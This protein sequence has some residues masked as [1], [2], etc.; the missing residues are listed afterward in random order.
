MTKY[1]LKQL[2]K[3]CIFNINLSII[4]NEVIDEGLINVRHKADHITNTLKSK[5]S[6]LNPSSIDIDTINDFLIPFNIKLIKT[7]PHG[8]LAA[9]DKKTSQIFINHLLFF[10]KKSLNFAGISKIKWNILSD[11]IEHEL[12]H[13]E[14]YSRSKGK[15]MKPPKQDMSRDQHKISFVSLLNNMSPQESQS[16]IR[17]YNNPA[18]IY[19]HCQEIADKIISF[20]KST[21]KPDEWNEN[22]KKTLNMLFQS[23]KGES[24]FIKEFPFLYVLSNDNK[25]KFLKTFYLIVVN[26]FNP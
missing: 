7:L 22:Y 9:F 1:Q 14:Q 5:L 26:S 13:R 23:P 17:Y 16:V 11:A 12:I 8:V 21:F 19:P 10:Y 3:E 20:I 18:E 25:K 2:I 24:F 6:T 4:L 15:D